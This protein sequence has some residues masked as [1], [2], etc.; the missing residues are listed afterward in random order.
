MWLTYFVATLWDDKYMKFRLKKGIE[1]EPMHSSPAKK[2]IFLMCAA[3]LFVI[4]VGFLIAR[5][6]S[7][8]EASSYQGNIAV[9][10]DACKLFSLDDA[11]EVLGKKAEASPNNANAVS[12][13]ATVSTCSYSSGSENVDDLIALTVLV[14]SSNKI[15]ARQAFEVARSANSEDV[16]GYGDQAY[17][18]PDASQL[19]VLKDD[20]WIIIASTKGTTGKGTSEIPKQVGKIILGRL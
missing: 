11:R 3:A 15:Q 13:K 1:E 4:S 5:N 20:T 14:R 16:K 6:V 17:Y 19:N 9:K 12:S 2:R 8:G 18:S 7:N 10:K